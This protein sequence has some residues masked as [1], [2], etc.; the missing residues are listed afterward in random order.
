MSKTESVKLFNKGKRTVHGKDGEHAYSLKSNE[1]MG[2]TPGHAAKL[3]KL[4]PN[5][6]ISMEDVQKSFEK[7]TEAP[8]SAQGTVTVEQMNKAVQEAVA[9]ALKRAQGKPAAVK[10]DSGTEPGNGESADDHAADGAP[11]NEGGI[12]RNFLDKITG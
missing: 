8:A 6:L 3:R 9:E 7:Q 2:F 11:A 10:E 4:Y 12:V 1:A 5:E